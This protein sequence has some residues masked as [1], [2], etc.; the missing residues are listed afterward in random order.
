MTE[1]RVPK[2]QCP[3][4]GHVLDAATG[5]GVPVPG[6]LAVCLYCHGVLVFTV[7]LQLRPMLAREWDALPESVKAQVEHMWQVLA[8]VQREEN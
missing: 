2:D 4:C 5:D 1:T 7:N 3:R 8:R 6:D